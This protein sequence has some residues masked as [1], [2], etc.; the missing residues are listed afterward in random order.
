MATTKAVKGRLLQKIDT[1]DNWSKATSFVPLKGEICI[2][3]DEGEA[4]KIKIGDGATN[5]N[6]LPFLATDII[7]TDE[8]DEVCGESIQMASEML[9]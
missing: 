6:D 5:I 8:I 2:Y 7:S 9:F 3:A 1:S 4:P